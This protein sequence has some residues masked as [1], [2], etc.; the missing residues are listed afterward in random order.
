[1]NTIYQYTTK[2]QSKRSVAY[3]GEI[4]PVRLKVGET[5]LTANERIQQ[6]DSTSNSEKLDKIFERTVP[7]HITDHVLHKALQRNGYFRSRDDKNREWFDFPDCDTAKEASRSVRTVLNKIINGVEAL[8]DWTSFAYQQDI[9]DWAVQRS[10]KSNDLLINAIMRAG[11]CRISYE[12]ARALYAKKILIVTAKVG[13]NDSWSSLLPQGEENHVDYAGWKY[14]NYKKVKSLEFEGTDVVFVSLQFIN[15]HIGK[16]NKLLNEILGVEWDCVFFDEQHYATTTDN[17]TRLWKQLDFKLK[18]ELSGTPYKTMLS[19][20]YTPEDT[21][22][23]DYVDEQ[24]IRKQLLD[25]NADDFLTDQFRKRADINYALV[26]IPEK[27][28]QLLG[29]EGFTFSKLLATENGNFK[30]V[31]GVNEFITF[32]VKNF[33]KP[34]AKFSSVADKLSRHTL[35][36]LP[37]NVE[38]IGLFTKALE[39][40]PFFCKRKIINAS[41]KGVKNIQ[42][43]KDIIARE[44][45]SGGAGTITITCGRFLEGTTVPEWW[46]VHQIN[47]DK[48]ASDYFQGSFRCKSPADGKES[49]LVYDYAPERFVSVVYDYCERVAEATNTT[50]EKVISTWLEVSD[51]YDYDGNAWNILTG[52]EISTRFLADIRNHIDRIGSCINQHEIDDTIIALLQDKSKDSNSNKSRTQFNANDIEEGKNTERNKKNYNQS[53][54]EDEDEL[55]VTMQ[56]IRYSLKQIYKLADIAWANDLEF[57]KIQDVT[58]LDSD[59]VAQV[60]GLTNSEWSSIMNTI[61][62]VSANRALGQYYEY[63]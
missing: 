58:Q 8:E 1:M 4:F 44:N 18:V 30:N 3:D 2:S 59:I 32:L 56:R 40:H 52:A 14:H 15:K 23:F 6:Q 49:V 21:Y 13:V 16:N 33:K 29:D 24:T 53:A 60:T 42:K 12:I 46:S 39:A 47:N 51:V 50:A 17:T 55:N 5:M 45:Y 61:N 28:K 19:G 63:Q 26:N 41:G 22:N 10:S 38:A 37:D 43:V 9:I 54:D 35:F 34:P 27:I 36:V 62:T 57:E 7:Q 11:K 31:M 20:R 48:S 25:V